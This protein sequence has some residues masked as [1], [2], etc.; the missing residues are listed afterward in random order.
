VAEWEVKRAFRSLVL[1]GVIEGPGDAARAKM[2]AIRQG[3]LPPLVTLPGARFACQGTGEC[4]QNYA[5]GPLDPEDVK[6]LQALDLSR[7]PNL[8][9]GPPVEE[10]E[11]G[12]VRGVFLKTVDER[13]V[14][15]EDGNRCGIHARAGAAAKPQ[16]CRQ[17]PAQRALTID[18]LKV[19]DRGECAAFAIAARSGE[20][21][22]DLVPAKPGEHLQITHPAVTLP[23]GLPCDYG[24]LAP[25]LSA[26][27]ERLGA[28]KGD[29]SGAI[30]LVA[31]ACHTFAEILTNVAMV[32]GE[33]EATLA[34]FIGDVR[35]GR[36]CEPPS[37]Q[38]R[39]MSAALS[40]VYALL[41]VV[42]S[43]LLRA[44]NG[45][46]RVANV[47]LLREVSEAL[48][49]LR[50]LLNA[51]MG[52]PL[53]EPHKSAARIALDPEAEDALRLSLRQQLFAERLLVSDR[54]G[55]GV[56]RLAAVHMISIAGSKLRASARGAAQASAADLSW[57]HHS[58][59][60]VLRANNFTPLLLAEEC[61]V[62]DVAAAAAAL[63]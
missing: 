29:A 56:L 17:Y 47:R 58:V 34:Q 6:S 60:I 20:P 51:A 7:F 62:W 63:G 48:F 11:V 5:Y 2:R 1:A 35:Q 14:F 43:S 32:P 61:R 54:L 41:G 27:V 39:A 42:L 44:Q 18:G 10:R 57:A 49:F 19:F 24:F 37:T 50:A 12:A 26:L 30:S 38:D 55:A 16:F 31:G 3:A 28:E 4:C 22:E 21:I 8:P 15:L 59:Q 53:E 36:P 52:E 13:C 9:P 25:L 23:D 33:P 45:D 46:T 40:L